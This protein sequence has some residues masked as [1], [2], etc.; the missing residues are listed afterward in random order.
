M[1]TANLLKQGQFQHHAGQK[2]DPIGETKP[3]NSLNGNTRKV[4]ARMSKPTN[5]AH[6][7]S[8]MYRWDPKHAVVH[9]D[10]NKTTGVTKTIYTKYHCYA[11]LTKQWDKSGM[12]LSF[13]SAKISLMSNFPVTTCCI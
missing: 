3:D 8:I 7:G 9:C 2:K 11:I 6:E 5:V 4:M 13:L 10:I 12:V 1:T